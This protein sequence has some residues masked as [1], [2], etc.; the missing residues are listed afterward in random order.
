MFSSG[1]LPERAEGLDRRLPTLGTGEY[2]W[3][4]FLERDDHP[5]AIGHPSGALL[6]WN[7]QAAPGFVHGDRGDHGS[8][9]GVQLLDRLDG[10][11]DL[12]G[13]VGV[14]N[15]AATQSRLSLVWPTISDTLAETDAPSP[16]AEAVRDLLD[17]WAADDAPVL[18]ADD[19]GTADHAGPGIFSALW[20]PLVT[21]AIEPVFGDQAALVYDERGLNDYKGASVLD[22]DL[23]A[24]LGRDVDGPFN[25]SYCGGGDLERCSSDLWEVVDAVAAELAGD[26]D[27]DD[28]STW[29]PEAE[30]TSFV[31]GLIDDTLR[32]TNRGTFQQLIELVQQRG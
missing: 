15:L 20:E 9:D 11:T 14:M 2:E 27:N 13:V 4:G 23:R 19:D 16:R 30:R 24:L 31:P 3:T 17:D 10:R 32:V 12:A 29:L 8:V 28:P 25:L 22:K 21:T 18:D 1:R 5:H 7:N 26:Y 6:S